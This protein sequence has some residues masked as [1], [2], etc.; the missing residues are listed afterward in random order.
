MISL[1]ND[2]C[3]QVYNLPALHPDLK[4]QFS[5]V[6]EGENVAIST[7]CTYMLPYLP[8]MR[9]TSVLHHEATSV[10]LI[11]PYTQYKR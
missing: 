11:L 2:I 3:I 8:P 1:T 10:F 4:I 7:S 5:Y 9:F 6:L